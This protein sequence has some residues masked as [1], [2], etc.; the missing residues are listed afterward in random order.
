[1]QKTAFCSGNVV[2]SF[3]KILLVMKL[4]I[5]LLI[6][7]LLNANARSF[8]QTVTYSGK[9]VTLD[10]LFTEIESQT[11]YSIFANK[12]LLQGVKP[13]TV[14]AKKMPIK[15]FLATI[16]KDEPID[17]EI[18]NRTIFI[19]EKAQ[20]TTPAAA[21]PTDASPPPLTITGTVTSTE[22]QAL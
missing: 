4:T 8:S 14:S 10:R 2:Q 18:E 9:N 7:G 16:L 20:T 1:M 6:V 21:S 3:T 11:G 13:V 17:F 19:K 15:D 22:G 12:D 5:A